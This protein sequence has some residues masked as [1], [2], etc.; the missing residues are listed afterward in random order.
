MKSK[1]LEVTTQAAVLPIARRRMS[2]DSSPISL[3]V[4]ERLFAC[5]MR[6]TRC[7]TRVRSRGVC[8]VLCVSS[9]VPDIVGRWTQDDG[10]SCLGRSGPCCVRGELCWGP[11]RFRPDVCSFR[12]SPWSRR[13]A[14]ECPET[15]AL[16]R[17]HRRDS[18]E[19]AVP[20][21]GWPCA[22][23]CD[24]VTASVP[25]ACALWVWRV[26]VPLPVRGAVPWPARAG[27]R[28]LATADSCARC[29]KRLIK[30]EEKR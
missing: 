29:I 19:T 13:H 2:L 9:S 30:A 22:C 21:G 7:K 20:V 12:L 28:P 8:V 17:R 23:E 14:C 16:E 18:R 5:S 25:G 26:A 3:L 27:T 11:A 24:S 15:P 1:S 4:R 10:V 6:V